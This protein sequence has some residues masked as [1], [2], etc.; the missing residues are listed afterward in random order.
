MFNEFWII[1]WMNFICYKNERCRWIKYVQGD[2][3][4][5]DIF[6]IRLDIHNTYISFNCV[7]RVSLDY[8]WELR[9]SRFV[10][11]IDPVIM[12]FSKINRDRCTKTP[13]IL[14]MTKAKKAS[15]TLKPLQLFNVNRYTHWRNGNCPFFGLFSSQLLW[16]FFKSHHINMDININTIRRYLQLV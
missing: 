9:Y 12:I 11:V 4:V 3:T 10:R 15:R 5:V 14:F 7:I 13:Y 1:I 2:T 16:F 6:K 8:I